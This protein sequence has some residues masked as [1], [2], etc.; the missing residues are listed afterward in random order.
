MRI[1]LAA[2]GEFLSTNAASAARTLAAAT[3]ATVAALTV[4]YV[5]WPDPRDAA[6]DVVVA[7]EPVFTPV[8]LT[9]SPPTPAPAAR[10]SAPG[11]L[12][13][14][15]FD[16]DVSVTRAVQGYLKRAGCYAGPVNGVWNRATSRA[17]GEFTVLVNARLPVDRPDPVH[18]VLLESHQT[19]SCRPDDRP[20]SRGGEDEIARIDEAPAV[21]PETRASLA[22]AASAADADLDEAS[23]SEP[24][25][26]AGWEE[27][28]AAA[29]AAAAAASQPKITN[30]ERR[31]NVRKSRKQPSLARQVSKGFRQL[32]RSLNKLF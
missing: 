30:P 11:G 25:M 15:R 26:V 29:A 16:D 14:S 28:A 3:G 12:A 23:P 27:T 10:P 18:L 5:V 6:V 9:P 2:L 31:R 7:A 20:A 4:V 22:P 8:A 21:A 1:D 24:A 17:M 13:P 32:Q 19:A